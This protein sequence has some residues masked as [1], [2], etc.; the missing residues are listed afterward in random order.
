MLGRE[1]RLKRG[2]VLANHEL[3]ILL[4]DS[5]VIQVVGHWV[6]VSPLVLVAWHAGVMGGAISAGF[7]A[8]E[9]LGLKAIFEGSASRFALLSIQSPILVFV[10]V[11]GQEVVSL[12]DL[13]IAV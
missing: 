9:E 7:Q 5:D 8:E 12:G 6:E 2:V 1:L 13:T 4:H 11:L 10:K 3:A